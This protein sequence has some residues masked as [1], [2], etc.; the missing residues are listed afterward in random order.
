MSSINDILNSLDGSHRAGPKPFLLTRIS[1][2]RS[3]LEKEE[4]WLLQAVYFL[5][6]PAVMA[7]CILL[8]IATIYIA[9]RNTGLPDATARQE[10]NNSYDDYVTGYY[11]SQEN[12]YK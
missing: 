10:T 3:A 2:R 5:T 7:I 11:L 1:S 6:R 12:I 9:A 4:H 8:C